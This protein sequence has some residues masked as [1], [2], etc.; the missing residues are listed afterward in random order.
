MFSILFL[1]IVT[2]SACIK[3]PAEDTANTSGY[4]CA[5]G[6]CISVSDNAQYTTLSACQAS[7]TSGGGGGGGGTTVRYKGRFVVTVYRP[8]G[9]C[10]SNP[11]TYPNMAFDGTLYAHQY[12]AQGIE[13]NYETLVR[14]NAPLFTNPNSSWTYTS[15]ADQS[16][17][18]WEL[19][20]CA[21]TWPSSC[22]IRG[23]SFIEFNGQ[24]KAVTIRW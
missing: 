8:T 24:T 1:A 18:I 13:T 4:N 3:L 22:T 15:L 9:T 19:Y 6:N 12:N 5:S 21:G 14:H 10:Q 17:L 16:G 11:N 20:P 2:L 7:C 23:Q